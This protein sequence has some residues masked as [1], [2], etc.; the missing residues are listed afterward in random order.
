MVEC[1]VAKGPKGSLVRTQQIQS[2]WSPRSSGLVDL[3]VHVPRSE[4]AKWEAWAN[5]VGEGGSFFARALEHSPEERF[6]S[7]LAEWLPP[8][9]PNATALPLSQ[10]ER[11]DIVNSAI[12]T[13]ST[14]MTIGEALRVS[15]LPNVV[16]RKSLNGHRIRISLEDTAYL[17]I[18]TPRREHC[19]IRLIVPK[20][21]I[22]KE[23]D[24]LRYTWL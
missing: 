4:K 5:Q 6:K 19:S 17:D 16:Y 7:V 22:P 23:E 11:R 15:P 13:W 14:F 2:L 24:D 18:E 1:E 8:R 21:T 9:H 10:A 20:S 12:S 3:H